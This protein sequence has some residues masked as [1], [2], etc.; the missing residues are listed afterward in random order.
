MKKWQVLGTTVIGASLLLGACGNSGGGSSDNGDSK[1][2]EVKGEVKGDGSS[3]VGP[4]IEILNEKFAQKYP[5]VTVSSGTS[6]T[7]G[8]FEKFINNETDF[9]NASRPIKD[10]EKKKLEEKGIKYSEWKIAK[11]GVTIAVN[12]DNDFVKELTV[13]ELKKIYSGQAKTWKDVNPKFPAKE[14]K[15]FSPDQSHGTYDFFS[16]EVMN[17]EDIKAEKNAD[18]NVIV[19]SVKN[20]KN[21]VGYFGYNFYEQNKDSLKEVKIKGKDGKAIEPTK[22][23][24]QDGSYAL[25]RDLYVYTNDKK[26]K[27]NKGLNTFIKFILE[28]KGKS[29]EKA[30][31]VALPEKDYKDQLKKLED[32]TK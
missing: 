25:S 29:A 12:K 13:D 17:K 6:G 26:L 23:S 20:N 32:S 21:G 8:G 19:Q 10:E 24:I 14:I 31:Y 15:A 5:N 3:T 18:T 27:D 4:I 9:S 22:K 28:D 2:K 11:D 16:E 1:D 7:G 30:G